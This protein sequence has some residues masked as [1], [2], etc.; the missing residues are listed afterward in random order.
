MDTGLDSLEWL[1]APP[2][3]A[4]EHAEELLRQLGAAGAT[5]GKWRALRCIPD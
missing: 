1:D 2:A 5:A 4:I 3:A